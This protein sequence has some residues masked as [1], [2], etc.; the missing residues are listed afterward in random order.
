VVPPLGKLKMGFFSQNDVLEVKKW[1]GGRL[2]SIPA[3]FIVF[4]HNKTT[5]KQSNKSP[6]I[7]VVDTCIIL[8][9]VYMPFIAYAIDI[10]PI[11]T[12]HYN[13]SRYG[14]LDK[15]APNASTKKPINIGVKTGYFLLPSI[16]QIIPC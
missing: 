11:K 14:Q 16:L 2:P 8:I 9:N 4:I 13:T 6:T 3:S 15:V 1:V 5:K 7:Y 10:I 12:Q